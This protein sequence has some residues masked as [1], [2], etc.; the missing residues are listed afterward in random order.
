MLGRIGAVLLTL[1][2]LTVSAAALILAR[3]DPSG[4]EN[5]DSQPPLEAAP[6]LSIQRETDLRVLVESF[7]IPVM[8]FMSGSSMLFVSGEARDFLL[9]GGRGRMITL[10]WQT[11][12]GIPMT[13]ESVY[14]ADALGMLDAGYHFS[15][16][17]GP[18]LFGATSVRMENGSNLRLHT[19]TESGLYVVIAP[20]ELAGQLSALSRSLQLFTV[21]EEATP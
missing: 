13:L 21:R 19:A 15:N 12:D 11:A 8:S 17:A 9:S 1:T 4:K 6:S 2:L 18:T 14:P 5:S 7:P 3:P 16:I 20:K 10:Y